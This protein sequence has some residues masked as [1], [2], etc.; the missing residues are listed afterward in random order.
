MKAILLVAPAWVGDLVMSQPLLRRLRERHPGATL[1]VF[2]APAL[3]PLV[4][5]LPEVRQGIPHSLR[6][7]ELGLAA[8][9]RLARSLRQRRYDQA[10]VL[11]NSFKSAWAPFLAGIPQRTGY[12]GE[13]RW[14]LL[15]DIR[16]LDK[17]RLPLM[18][19][20]FAALAEPAGTAW[21]RPLPPPRL[22]VDPQTVRATLERLGLYPTRP[23]A[24]L[25]PGAEY[26]PAKRW[27]AAYFGDL[28]R[29]LSET[30]HDVWVVGG[31]AD[32]SLGETIR[33]QAGEHCFN[34]CGR[35]DLGEAVDVISTARL[36]VSNDS[37]LMHVAAALDRP[38]LALFGSSSPG[39]TPPL[40]P[41]A[42]VIRLELPCSPCFQR[43]CP[44]GHFRCMK[45]L[46]PQHVLAHI[47]PE[48]A[49]P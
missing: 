2:A 37:G 42:R 1:D 13:A 5:R 8:R 31:S 4:Q 3:L 39:F 36:V 23:T 20:R 16:R 40:S 17:Q 26:G 22:R 21:P 44:L 28:A 49:R 9:W 45:D 33:A 25:C 12:L 46:T 11:P 14:G 32:S 15:N 7:G 48:F 19:E 35:T 41:R 34:L 10:I 38:L 29:H 24:V 18:V 43:E 27:P 47:T 6:H 30:G